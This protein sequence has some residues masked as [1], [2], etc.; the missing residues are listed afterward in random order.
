MMTVKAGRRLVRREEGS[1]LLRKRRLVDKQAESA[2][3]S[4][5]DAGERKGVWTWTWLSMT[6]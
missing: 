4:G 3:G 1:E 6:I 5:D 2:E